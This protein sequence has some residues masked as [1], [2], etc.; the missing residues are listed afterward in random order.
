M[1]YS[2][3][4][5][6]AYRLYTREFGARLSIRAFAELYGHKRRAAATIYTPKGMDDAFLTPESPEEAQIRSWIDELNAGEARKY[7]EQLFT[8][9]TRQV[10]AERM[11]KIKVT[12]K[13]QE[14]L[15]IS[16]NKID[17]AQRKLDD[18]RRTEPKDRD[19]R[20]FPFWYAPVM[21][22]EE[23][24]LVVKPMRY[25]CRLP[26]WTPSMERKYGTYNAFG[27]LLTVRRRQVPDLM[28]K[29]PS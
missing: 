1:C 5:W 15:R 27:A 28:A 21:V 18:L 20:I 3:Q 2:A 8:Q 6:T 7:E 14:D 9:K 19:S 12:K 11:L 4:C 24:H 29:R 13:T 17:Q 26:G 22:M 10:A 16:T 23:G 25:H